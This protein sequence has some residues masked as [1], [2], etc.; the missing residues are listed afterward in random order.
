MTLS[1]SRLAQGQES[2][3][4]NTNG[5][6]VGYC[7]GST[8]VCVGQYCSYDEDRDQECFSRQACPE[9]ICIPHQKWLAIPPQDPDDPRGNR[10]SYISVNNSRWTRFHTAMATPPL[11]VKALSLF[12][13]PPEKTFTGDSCDDTT[14]PIRWWNGSFIAVGDVIDQCEMYHLL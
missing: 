8:P 10:P 2:A 12:L 11:A 6:G 1:V 5:V 4:R 14:P 7:S 13:E 9:C 3:C